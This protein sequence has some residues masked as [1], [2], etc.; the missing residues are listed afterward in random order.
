MVRRVRQKD[1]KKKR[2]SGG[3][4]GARQKMARAFRIVRLRLGGYVPVRRLQ[5]KLSLHLIPFAAPS[6]RGT[7]E[8]QTHGMITQP[9]PTTAADIGA[10]SEKS[11]PPGRNMECS[12]LLISA[13]HRA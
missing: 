7:P 9:P 11:F 8:S 1:K 12:P 4:F 13:G 5:L 2:W 10:R 3:A 6:S